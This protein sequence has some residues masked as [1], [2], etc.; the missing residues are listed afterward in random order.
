MRVPTLLA[1]LFLAACVPSITTD[2]DSP[3]AD[4]DSTAADDDSTAMDDDSTAGDDDTMPSDD[5]S[6]PT[7]DDSTE[8]GDDDSVPGDD[9]T[10]P[11]GSLQ[12][13]MTCGDPVCSGWSASGNPI[14]AGGQVVGQPCELRDAMCDPM[15][16]CNAQYVCTDED[17]AINCPISRRDAKRDIRYLS[18]AE[19]EQLS[20]QVLTMSLASW[21]YAIP[22]QPEGPHTGFIIEDQL[23][24]SPAVQGDRV[25]LYGFTAMTVAAIQ[26]QQQ[27]LAALRAEIVQ[28]RASCAPAQASEATSRK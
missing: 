27:E 12:W 24:G 4:D 5:D 19:K 6:V 8:P 21:E 28:L 18:T 13:Y 26:T 16:G 1:L 10:T 3:T 9:D 22:G 11:G 7:D 2:D 14:C 20:T 25:D 17:P 15:D 23:P